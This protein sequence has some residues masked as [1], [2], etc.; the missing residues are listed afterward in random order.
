MTEWEYEHV[1]EFGDWVNDEEEV[2]DD[3]FED[4]LM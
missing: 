1:N 3:D 2:D 4:E